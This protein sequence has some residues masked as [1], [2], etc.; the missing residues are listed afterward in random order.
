MVSGVPISWKSKKQTCVALSTA[1]AEYIVLAFA[2]R[3]L[4]WLRELF[5]DLHNE[6]TKIIKQPCVL[7][8]H[9]NTT[10]RPNT[11]VYIKYKYHYVREKVLDNT[12]LTLL[13]DK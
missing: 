4:T 13:S 2:T 9:H 3:E 8:S 6:Q 12:I 7:Q 1:E 5:K 10:A 11:L